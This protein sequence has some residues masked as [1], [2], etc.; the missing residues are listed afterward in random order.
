MIATAAKHQTVEENKFLRLKKN[1]VGNS[2]T[3]YAVAFTIITT[4]QMRNDFLIG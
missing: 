3:G 1:C 2:L 4:M